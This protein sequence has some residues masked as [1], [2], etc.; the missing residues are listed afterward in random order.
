MITVGVRFQDGTEQVIGQYQRV[1][2]A[3]DALTSS[4][5][6]YSEAEY[7]YLEMAGYDVSADESVVSRYAKLYPKDA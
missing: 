1:V 6:D 4:L 3:N 5:A 7:L 2:E